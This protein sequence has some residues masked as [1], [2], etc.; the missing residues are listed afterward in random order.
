MSIEINPKLKLFHNTRHASARHRK[1]SK[2]ENST[3][4]WLANFDW[5]IDTHLGWKRGMSTRKKIKT[6]KVVKNTATKKR[7][8]KSRKNYFPILRS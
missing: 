4:P 1:L 3:S 7:L 8:K 6:K 2:E 5:V